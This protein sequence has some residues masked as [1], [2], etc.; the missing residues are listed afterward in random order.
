MGP[1]PF[2]VTLVGILIVIG[3][4]SAILSGLV[5]LFT[6][7]SLGLGIVAL[8]VLLVVGLIYLAV[9]K[10]IF[11]GSGGARMIVGIVTVVSIIGG[12]FALFGNPLGG[13]LQIVW[14]LIILALLYSGKAKAFFA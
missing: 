8:I 10:G 2:G 11:A 4:I 1:R 13:I 7:D 12:F 3:G 14:G 5:G 9:A 6:G